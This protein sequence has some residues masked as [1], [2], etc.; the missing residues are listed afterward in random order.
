MIMSGKFRRIWPALRN[1]FRH[2]K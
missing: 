1:L 2:K